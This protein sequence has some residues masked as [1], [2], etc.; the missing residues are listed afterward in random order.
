M[1]KPL[2]G[3]L[4]REEGHELLNRIA[5]FGRPTP[6]VVFT[7]GDPLMRNDLFDQFQHATREGLRFAVSPA[8]T[9][10]LSHGTLS[11]FKEVGVSSISVSLDGATSR[12]HDYI[13]S[14]A[15]TF[16]RSVAAI[17]DSVITGLNPQVNTTVMINNCGELAKIFHLVKTIGVKTWEVFFLVNV[18]RGAYIDAL[19]PSQHED[20]CNFLYEASHYGVT[21]R[22]V[23]AP[24][25]RRIVKSRSNW[26]NY[27]GGSLYRKLHAELISYEGTPTERS[28]IGPRG[29]LDG[30]GVI[31]VGYD[32]TIC[33]GGLLPVS[34]GNVRENDLVRVY[35]EN[36]LLN[37][38]R[39]RNFTGR[40][41]VCEFKEICGG[42]RARAASATGSPLAS[43]PACL[44]ASA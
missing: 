1:S 11:K 8:V 6:T 18:G 37:S 7:G 29:T 21:I 3:E 31:F 20:V 10:R 33:P 5:S 16:Q 24:F 36:E 2:P 44:L 30:D 15:G 25:I 12:T 9:G 40:C 41:G 28:T 32:G 34:L 22:C 19:S 27:Q 39:L 17:R 14:V 26:P 35:R 4:S 13:R 42:S 38:I 43:D 23:E